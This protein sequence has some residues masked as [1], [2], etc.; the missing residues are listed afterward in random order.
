MRHV[1]GALGGSVEAADGS[2]SDDDGGVP[3]G[4]KGLRVQLVPDGDVSA[5]E[6]MGDVGRASGADRGC[7]DDHDVVP[8]PL[9]LTEIHE[10]G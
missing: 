5:A 6:E 1:H 9:G 3:V 2:G 8:A 10:L 7:E 4:I